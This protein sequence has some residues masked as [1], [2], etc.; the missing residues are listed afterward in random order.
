[1]GITLLQLPSILTG[2]TRTG[3][4]EQGTTAEDPG[5]LSPRLKHGENK[6]LQTR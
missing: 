4:G 6:N 2:G 3:S 1:M 5:A